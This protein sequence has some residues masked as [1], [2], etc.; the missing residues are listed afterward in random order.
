MSHDI[1]S[2]QRGS[3]RTLRKKTSSVHLDCPDRSRILCQ[4]VLRGFDAS[5]SPTPRRLKA[6]RRCK[7]HA[8]LASHGTF[9][10]TIALIERRWISVRAGLSRSS[11]SP[12]ALGPWSDRSY[13]KRCTRSEASVHGYVLRDLPIVVRVEILVC[14]TEPMPIIPEHANDRPTSNLPDSD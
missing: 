13:L 4:C 9:Y 14:A 8:Y 10:S 6:N 5:A 3:C 11:V 12:Q 2:L 7:V 1:K